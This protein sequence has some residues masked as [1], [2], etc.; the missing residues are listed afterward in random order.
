MTATDPKKPFFLT[1]QKLKI[2]FEI[3]IN[4]HIFPETKFLPLRQQIASDEAAG[5][6]VTMCMATGNLQI[7]FRNRKT[8]VFKIN[9]LV[10][11]ASKVITLN[12]AEK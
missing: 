11:A 10:E 1:F 4:A 12:S 8:V 6:S 9:E 5:V 3:S 2:M 7:E